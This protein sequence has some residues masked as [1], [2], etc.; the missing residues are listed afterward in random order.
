MGMMIA[1]SL[2]LASTLI[3]LLGL[4]EDFG[5]GLGQSS[6]RVCRRGVGFWARMLNGLAEFPR[7]YAYRVVV[8]RTLRS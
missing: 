6:L 7:G 5:S 2:I 8:V 4:A 3:C 1:H